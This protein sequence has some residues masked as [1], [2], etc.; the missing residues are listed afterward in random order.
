MKLRDFGLLTDE[1]IDVDVVAHFR[2]LGFDVIDVCESG[3]RGS[4]DVDLLRLAVTQNRLLVSHDA[5]FGTLAV[6]AGEPV[7]GLIYLRP[8]HIDSQFTIETIQ[9]VINADPDVH[10]PFVLVAKRRGT[11]V[12]IRIRS[13]SP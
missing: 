11:Q 3:L 6:L 5:D 2:S 9:A 1:N 4:S 10:V 13:L 8:G 12:A 7:I